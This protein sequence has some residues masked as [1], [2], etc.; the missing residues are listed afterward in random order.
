[1]ENSR[2][3]LIFKDSFGLT[4]KPDGTLTSPLTSLLIFS[5]TL[6]Q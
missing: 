6:L 5:V 1:M 3:D 2:I 4:E